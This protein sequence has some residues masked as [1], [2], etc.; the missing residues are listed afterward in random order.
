[1]N[2]KRRHIGFPTAHTCEQFLIFVVGK[3]NPIPSNVGRKKEEQF[4][5]GE[6]QEKVHDKN[7]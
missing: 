4:L 1:M 3:K 7:F 2:S 6:L 5:K